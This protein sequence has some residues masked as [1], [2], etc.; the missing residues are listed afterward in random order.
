MNHSYKVNSNGEFNFDL[1][2]KDIHGSDVIK[3]P[4]GKFHVLQE[5]KSFVAEIKE[6]N[7]DQ[8]RYTVVVNNK[9][10][11]VRISN[12]LDLLVAEMGF[13]LGATKHV[14]SIEAPMPGLILSIDIA[15]GKEVAAGDPLLILEAMKMENVITA[16]RNG[17]IKNI[18]VKQGDAVTKKQLL[19]EFEK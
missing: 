8:K 1:S 7:F 3:T 12:D 11:E 16:P 2:S 14:D 5:N 13:S 15:V 17:I 10:Y 19:I 9:E 6:K 18:N 4:S